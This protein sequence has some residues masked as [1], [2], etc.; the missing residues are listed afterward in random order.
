MV[1]TIPLFGALSDRI[2]R[3]RTYAIGALLLALCVFPA[4][5]V[6]HLTMASRKVADG[7]WNPTIY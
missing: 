1:F 5:E 7:A 4:G 3:P 2:G 6:S